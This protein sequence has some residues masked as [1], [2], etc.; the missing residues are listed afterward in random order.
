MSLP[1]PTTVQ[2]LQTALHTK[3]KSRVARGN[4][5]PGPSRNRTGASR[6][7][8]LF[9]PGQRP[10][11]ISRFLLMTQLTSKCNRV[12]GLLGSMPITGTS[13][14]LQAHP[15]LCLASVLRPLWGYHLGCSLGIEATGSQVTRPSPNRTHATLMPDAALAVSGYPQR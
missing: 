9:S 5:T 2:K 3:A 6:L 13:T 8:R 7:I 4:C 1:P 15:P 10:C 12:S 14:L 11:C